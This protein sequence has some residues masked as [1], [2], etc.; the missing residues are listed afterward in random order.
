MPFKRLCEKGVLRMKDVISNHAKL[1]SCY[2]ESLTAFAGTELQLMMKS[3]KVALLQ[4]KLKTLSEGEL[5]N[6]RISLL[7][8]SLLLVLSSSATSRTPSCPF[9]HAALKGISALAEKHSDQRAPHKSLLKA[10]WS[11]KDSKAKL[12]KALKSLVYP[13]GTPEETSAKRTLLQSGGVVGDP[14]PPKLPKRAQEMAERHISEGVKTQWFPRSAQKDIHDKSPSARAYQARGIHGLVNDLSTVAKTV[15]VVN[16]DLEAD[17]TLTF[18]K[19]VRFTCSALIH[20][21]PSHSPSSQSNE[22]SFT[23]RDNPRWRC[24]CPSC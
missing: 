2:K 12:D 1:S 4:K 11:D 5:C 7:L 19:K 24:E 8:S 13:E 3:R 9:W 15:G 14:K 23:E 6:G 22:P 16:E 21:R 10:I 17:L 20:W 18:K